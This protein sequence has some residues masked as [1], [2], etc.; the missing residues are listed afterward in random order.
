MNH[1]N[2]NQ[3]R[4][5]DPWG[6]YAL[7]CMKHRYIFFMAFCDDVPS[8]FTSLQRCCF[9]GSDQRIGCGPSSCSRDTGWRRGCWVWPPAQEQEPLGSHPINQQKWISFGLQMRRPLYFACIRWAPCV[10]KRVAIERQVLLTLVFT[11]LLY[12]YLYSLL[13]LLL[14]SSNDC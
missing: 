10:A 4:I 1:S 11:N 5:G 8:K 9:S 12:L 3:L 7:K 13:L 2:R 14:P 6:F